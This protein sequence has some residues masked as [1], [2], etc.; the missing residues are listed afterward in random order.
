MTIITANL[1]KTIA[2]PLKPTDTFNKISL[3]KN[4]VPTVNTLGLNDG[5]KILGANLILKDLKVFTA[6]K[7]LPIASMP[8]LQ[9]VDS[10][11]EKILKLI[12]NENHSA[13]F[14]LNLY[15]DVGQDDL[16]IGSLSILN[17][18]GY[19]YRYYNLL[20]VI[21]GGLEL[22]KDFELKIS[23]QNV[24]YGYI[25]PTDIINVI[26]YYIQEIVILAP[27]TVTTVNGGNNNNGGNTTGITWGTMTQ[28]QWLDTTQQQWLN[29]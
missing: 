24:G 28:Q 27:D 10:D 9:L 29:I 20:D 26:G 6:V 3:A 16:I 12:E 13:K 22:S 19:R 2:V 23:Q 18:Q 17:T 1:I 11:T 21:S 14:Q 8:D 7:S 25:K 4:V 15:L 5:Y